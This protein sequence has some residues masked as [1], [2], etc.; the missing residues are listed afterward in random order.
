[1]L[2]ASRQPS[3]WSQAHRPP[4]L[5]HDPTQTPAPPWS[6]RMEGIP[7]LGKVRPGVTGSRQPLPPII[8]PNLSPFIPPTRS[9]NPLNLVAEQVWEA[10]GWAPAGK[11][12]SE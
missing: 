1:M 11:H 7:G 9:P 5:L 2:G 4:S 10:S 8:G 3:Q 12:L 6:L